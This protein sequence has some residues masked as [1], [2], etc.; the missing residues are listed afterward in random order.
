[1]GRSIFC[2]FGAGVCQALVKYLNSAISWVQLKAKSQREGMYKAS[3]PLLLKINKFITIK[4][5]L[6]LRQTW[7]KRCIACEQHNIKAKNHRIACSKRLLKSPGYRSYFMEKET[8]AQRRWALVIHLCSHP[9]VISKKCLPGVP[10]PVE[11]WKSVFLWLHGTY[12]LVANY[13]RYFEMWHDIVETWEKLEERIKEA[14]T[15]G[16]SIK[17]VLEGSAGLLQVQKGR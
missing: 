10:S 11:R 13:I 12:Y 2:L 4:K 1:M 3:K 9:L 7:N 16:H 15:G 6:T 14:F 5:A 8:D 17:L